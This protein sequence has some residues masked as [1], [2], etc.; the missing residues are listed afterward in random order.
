MQVSHTSKRFTLRRIVSAAA[1]V[2]FIGV[3]AALVLNNFMGSSKGTSS[4]NELY[5]MYEAPA[6]DLLGVRSITD[7][8]REPS[9]DVKTPDPNFVA[10]M[11]AYDK[12]DYKTAVDH[13]TI[14]LKNHPERT[15]AALY[16]GISLLETNQ[17]E[18]A[19]KIFIGLTS[20]K[21]YTFVDYAE[22]Y[23]SLSYLKL[24]DNEACVKLLQ[25]ISADPQHQYH[26]E[27]AVLL[28]K[29]K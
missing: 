10:G 20:D 18:A 4:N 12:K 19:K 8:N 6:N 26:S 13:L 14:L 22:W 17:T 27:A 11:E 28:K 23:L 9:A 24:N 1:V 29:L 3:P 7:P 25:S 21:S 15:D 16:L 5:A 2:L